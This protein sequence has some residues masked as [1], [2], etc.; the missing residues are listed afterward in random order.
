MNA[1]VE[2]VIPNSRALLGFFGFFC[3]NAG[4]EEYQDHVTSFKPSLGTPDPGLKMRKHLCFCCC[5]LFVQQY[6]AIAVLEN[7]PPGAGLQKRS[8]FSTLIVGPAGTGDQTRATCVAG[9]GNNR[10]AI[11]YPAVG[12]CAVP[13]LLA[14]ASLCLLY[15]DLF[16]FC[17]Q[18]WSW[19]QSR[20]SYV[21]R[22][23]FANAYI[24]NQSHRYRYTFVDNNNLINPL[25]L[26]Y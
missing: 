3:N 14:A 20:Y 7:V 11:H 18:L 25:Q 26:C 4:S 1:H 5:N 23:A 6:S 2:R 22:A 19:H 9:S 24:A 12:M 21:D 17:A 8:N 13:L 16:P 15:K 10:S